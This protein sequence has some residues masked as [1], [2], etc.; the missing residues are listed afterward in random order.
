MPTVK[1]NNRFVENN[2]RFISDEDVARYSADGW[3]II[4]DEDKP[5]RVEK[6]VE[7]I[8]EPQVKQESKNVVY[9]EKESEQF[10]RQRGR[11]KKY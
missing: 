4:Q 8:V 2:P 11:P 3:F 10:Q 9:A 6:P 7:V 5:L 1:H